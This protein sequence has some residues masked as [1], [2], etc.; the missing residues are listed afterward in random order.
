MEQILQRE[1]VTLKGR[2][3]SGKQAGRHKKVLFKSMV[4]AKFVFAKNGENKHDVYH[5]LSICSSP[6]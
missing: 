4:H 5:A 3:L 6:R 2:H 1:D